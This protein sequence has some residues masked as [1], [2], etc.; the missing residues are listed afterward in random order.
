MKIPSVPPK[1]EPKFEQGLIWPKKNNKIFKI[2]I[3]NATQKISKN[4]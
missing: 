2:M 3:P 4:C 1:K